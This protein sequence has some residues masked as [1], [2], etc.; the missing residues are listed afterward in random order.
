MDGIE[1]HN[2]FFKYVQYIKTNIAKVNHQLRKHPK[3][4]Q[5]LMKGL[6]H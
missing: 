6:L 2:S 3:T 5:H 1:K 4:I